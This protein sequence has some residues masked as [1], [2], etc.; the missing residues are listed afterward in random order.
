MNWE[1]ESTL[2]DMIHSVPTIAKTVW[3]C[4]RESHRDQMDMRN[5]SDHMALTD[6]LLPF[7]SFLFLVL[8][9]FE[10]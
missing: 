8:L 5:L 9:G 7:F 6:S 1:E 10:L 4:S 3:Y 2:H